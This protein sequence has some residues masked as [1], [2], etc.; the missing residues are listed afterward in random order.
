MIYAFNTIS[1]L[2]QSKLILQYILLTKIVYIVIKN[3]YLRGTYVS[4]IIEDSEGGG[5]L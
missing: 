3:I 4:E 1:Q 2:N 5:A